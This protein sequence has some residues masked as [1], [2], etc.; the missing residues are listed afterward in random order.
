MPSNNPKEESKRDLR[1]R[2]VANNPCSIC[3]ALGIP[4]CRGHGAGGGGGGGDGD[5]N[6]DTIDNKADLNSI[7]LDPKVTADVNALSKSL[8]QTEEWH[9]SEDADLVL[10]FAEPSA[11]VHIIL[12]MEIGSLVFR[13][14]RELS[15]EEQKALDELF[16]AIE[17]ELA[18]FKNELINMNEPIQAIKMVREHDSLSIKIP[19]P[20]HYDLF[21]QSLIDKNLLPNTSTAEFN[22]NQSITLDPTELSS[23]NNKS[24]APTPF[25]IHGPKPQGWD[26]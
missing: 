10:E 16:D 3:R 22:I 9:Q 6:S 14:S 26:R 19:D 24:R 4:V 7:M 15:E 21:I 17:K 5:T 2:A 20:K 25:D 23:D 8:I 18:L 1:A 13:A 12:N 11:Y